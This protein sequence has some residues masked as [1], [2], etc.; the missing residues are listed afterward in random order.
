MNDIKVSKYSASMKI[1]SFADDITE[2]LVGSSL[3]ELSVKVNSGLAKSSKSGFV[4]VN[5]P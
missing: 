3:K 5:Y 1:S 4:Q 2:Y